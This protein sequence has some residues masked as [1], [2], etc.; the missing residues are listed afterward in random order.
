MK[1]IKVEKTS[2]TFDKVKFG[3]DPVET[4]D[5]A[6]LMEVVLDIVPQGGFTPKDIRDRNRIQNAIE[7]KKDGKISLEDADYTN[8]TKVLENSRWTV[9]HIE[10][11]K[12]LDSFD[13]K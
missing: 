7:D 6:D 12:F 8:F 9:R 10:L 4:M 5:Y 3:G 11:Q 13:K 2:I 1:T